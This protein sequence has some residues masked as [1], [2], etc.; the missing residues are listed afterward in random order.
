MIFRLTLILIGSNSISNLHSYSI[1]IESNR[2]RNYRLKIIASFWQL[3][4]ADPYYEEDNNFDETEDFQDVDETDE[5]QEATTRPE[6]ESLIF[7]NFFIFFC[8]M[9]KSEKALNYLCFNEK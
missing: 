8:K 4:Y 6:S 9:Q 7:F 5:Y 3:D 2:N 1:R